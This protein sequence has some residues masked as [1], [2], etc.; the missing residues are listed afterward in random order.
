MDELYLAP[1]KSI[2]NILRK[3]G[4]GSN[5][6][7]IVGHNPGIAECALWLARA[8]RSDR[9]QHRHDA[10]EAKFPTAALAVLDFDIAEWRDVS[11]Q[12]GHL[13]DF[14]KPKE[15]TAA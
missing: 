5:G 12:S 15:L 8:P 7:L 2:A 9:E 6:V 10:L 14:L 11:P 4:G 13:V 1:V 3:F